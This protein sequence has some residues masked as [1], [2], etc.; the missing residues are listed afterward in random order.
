MDAQYADAY[1]ELY[2]HHWWWRVREEILLRKIRSIVTKTPHAR[3]LDVGCGAGLFFDQLEQFG[4]VE[5]VESDRAAVQAS[6]R[7]RPRIAVGNLDDTYQSAAPFDL[8]LML[9][10]LE[11]IHD[12]DQIVRRAAELLTPSGRILVTVP[13]FKWLWTAHDDMNHHVTRYSARQLRGMLSRNGLRVIEARYMFQSL[14][15]PKLLVR[16]SEA[17]APRPPRVPA[18]ARRPINDVLKIWFRAEYSLAGRLPFGGS[19][20]AVAAN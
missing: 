13:A 18:I 15:L 10:V 19:L 1:P 3:I 9:D 17:L 16:A 11:H 2:R 20:L 8:I 6:G 7:W 4:H 14:V 5:G 12:T